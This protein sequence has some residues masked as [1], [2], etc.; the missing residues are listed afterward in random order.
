MKTGKKRELDSLQGTELLGHHILLH[1]DF[2]R[3][4]LFWQK[5]I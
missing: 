2:I 3:Y 1:S 5:W 4:R